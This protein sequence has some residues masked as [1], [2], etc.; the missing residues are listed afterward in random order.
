MP[1]EPAGSHA[2]VTRCGCRVLRADLDMGSAERFTQGVPMNVKPNPNRGQSDA[3][4]VLAMSAARKS[5]GSSSSSKGAGARGR[6]ESSRSR[7]PGAAVVLIAALGVLSMGWA[8]HRQWSK[9]SGAPYAEASRSAVPRASGA[10]LADA[11]SPFAVAPAPLPPAERVAKASAAQP[12]PLSFAV[13]ADTAASEETVLL[14]SLTAP[15]EDVRYHSLEHALGTGVDV[16][17]DTLQDLLANDPSDGV[18]EL[19][20]QGLTERP[21]ATREEIRAILDAAVANPSAVVRASAQRTIEQM[22]VLDQM[23]ERARAFRHGAGAGI[24]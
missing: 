19:A 13:S 7:G 18:R 23:D 10:S 16:P 1:D 14:E 17:Q 15:H 8:L 24:E 3:L 12:G 5:A 11:L 22:N 21:E 9:D 4:Q 6:D 20:L 2:A